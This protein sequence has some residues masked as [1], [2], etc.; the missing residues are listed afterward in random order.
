MV[1]MLQ[2]LQRCFSYN[3]NVVYPNGKYNV[4]GSRSRILAQLD[5]DPVINFS[6]T[7]LNFFNY[8]KIVAPEEMFSQLSLW[9]VNFCLK[10][11]PFVSNLSFFTFIDM[12]PYSD[13]GSGS[14]KLLNAAPNL[15][16]DPPHWLQTRY[17]PRREKRVLHEAKLD[18]ISI[19]FSR[20]QGARLS[21]P[22]LC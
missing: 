2:G 20:W 6:E 5:P 13:N 15:D 3:Y 21:P 14:I 1:K 4:F 11:T 19:R 12:D 8:E 7:I 17:N 10:Y 9:R 18:I 16:P 22:L